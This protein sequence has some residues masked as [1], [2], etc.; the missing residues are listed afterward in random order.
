MLNQRLFV[1][2]LDGLQRKLAAPPPLLGERS[3]IAEA[4][5]LI[6][7]SVADPLRLA[8]QQSDASKTSAQESR[9]PYLVHRPTR[10]AIGGLLHLDR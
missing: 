7:E 4:K 3:A 9:W 2:D 1:P 6:L 5:R 8:G 10:I